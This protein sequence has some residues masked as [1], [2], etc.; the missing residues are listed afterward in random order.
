VER[1]ASSFV[2]PGNS[3]RSFRHLGSGGCRVGLSLARRDATVL[4]ERRGRRVWPL[5]SMVLLAAFHRSGAPLL[6]YVGPDRD[7]KQRE[8]GDDCGYGECDA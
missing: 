5:A 3:A 1:S 7:A 4:I 8:S 2:P 6:E